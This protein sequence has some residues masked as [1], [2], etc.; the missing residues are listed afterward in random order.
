MIAIFLSNGIVAQPIMTDTLLFIN[1]ENGADSIIQFYNI[2]GSSFQQGVSLKPQLTQGN[3]TNNS[4]ITDTAQPYLPNTFSYFEVPFVPNV[5]DTMMNEFV[6]PLQVCFK[7][8]LHIDSLHAGAWI[9]IADQ[10]QEFNLAQLQQW[11]QLNGNYYF[12]FNA[13]LY[14]SYQSTDTL[15]NQ[16]LG[17]HQTFLEWK[18]TCFDLYWIGVSPPNEERTAPDTM[19]IRFLFA[20]DNTANISYEGWIIDDIRIGKGDGFCGGSLQNFSNEMKIYPNPTSGKIYL[21]FPETA[22]TF[23]ITEVSIFDVTG[24]TVQTFVNNTVPDFLDLSGYPQGLYI[25][26]L[27]NEY[28]TWMSPVIQY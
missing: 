14:N 20:S 27:Q 28:N 16:E 23:V 3:N 8:R 17:F 21:E 5:I 11:F 12:Y 19:F 1:F 4:I 6:C 18:E 15:F 9:E 22:E 2:S 25:I 26:Q 10:D 7:H 13:D 24:K